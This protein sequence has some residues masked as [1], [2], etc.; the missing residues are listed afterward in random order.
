M[1][2]KKI[3][4]NDEITK[5]QLKELNEILKNFIRVLKDVLEHFLVILMRQWKI[6]CLKILAK[7]KNN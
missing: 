6:L 2:G 1:I 3:W 7:R 4:E 5:E